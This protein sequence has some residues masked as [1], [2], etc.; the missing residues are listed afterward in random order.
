MRMIIKLSVYF[1]ITLV[2]FY[3]HYSD[4]L[5]HDTIERYKVIRLIIGFLI[6]YAIVNSA[7]L[8]IKWSYSRRHK[9]KKGQKNNVHYGIENIAKLVITVG[10]VTTAL[11]S[12]GI[13][14]WEVITSIT[15]VATAIAIL[16]KEYI[17]DFLVGI[18]LSFSSMF[19]V[20][21]FVKMGDKKGEVLGINMLKTLI[22]NEEDD[23]VLLPN[24][25]VHYNQIVNYTQ[26]DI[27]QMSVDFQLEKEYVRETEELKMRIKQS[28]EQLKRYIDLESCELEVINIKNEHFDLKLNYTLLEVN[29][30]IHQKARKIILQEVFQFILDVDK[31]NVES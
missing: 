10:F 26:K 5:L 30:D 16:T 18:H 17:S 11:S 28:L 2:L 12:F 29:M 8:V 23:V 1:I 3:I 15:I 14:L 9:M 24:T 22:R 7:A 27:R 13:Q 19:E 4:S 31:G 20:G 21:D 6:F 25:M